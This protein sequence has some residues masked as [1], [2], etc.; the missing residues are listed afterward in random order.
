MPV[1]D[2]A[3]QVVHVDLELLQQRPDHIAVTQRE[4]QMFGIDLGAAEFPCFLRGLLQELVALF[5]KTIGDARPALAA[6]VS[7]DVFTA[8]A[9]G[10][11]VDSTVIVGDEK[12]VFH[13]VPTGILYPGV[14]CVIGNGTVVD[15]AGIEDER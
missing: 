14:K 15:P 10:G 5:A 2:L 7:A 3:A 11:V 13:H 9:F 4:E 12:F 1:V 6:P 8:D